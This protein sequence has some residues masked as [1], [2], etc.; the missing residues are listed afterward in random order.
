MIE[1][2]EWN[3]FHSLFYLLWQTGGFTLANVPTRLDGLF[4]SSRRFSKT[5][6]RVGQ[7]MKSFLKKLC[8]VFEELFFCFYIDSSFMW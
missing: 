2:R 3:H 4:H 1:V 7:K 8:Q 5:S 6:R